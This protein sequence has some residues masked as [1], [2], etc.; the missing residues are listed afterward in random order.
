MGYIFLAVG[1]VGRPIGAILFGF[2]GDKY[3][4][5]PALLMSIWELK[6]FVELWVKICFTNS[7]RK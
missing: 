2:V 6:Y 4:R 5:K 7:Y 1:F 3:G